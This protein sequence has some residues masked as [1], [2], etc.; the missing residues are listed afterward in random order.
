MKKLGVAF[1]LTGMVAAV[2][3]SDPS[4]IHPGLKNAI[5]AGNIE[6]AENIINK[7]GVDDLYCPATL[8]IS[9]AERLYAKRLEYRPLALYECD[10]WGQSFCDSAFAKKYVENSCNGKRP[11][12]VKVCSAWMNKST[13]REWLA[14]EKG[15]CGSKETLENC[16]RLI[17][18][19]KVGYLMEYFKSLEKKQL[20]QY[21]EKVPYDTTVSEPIPVKECLANIEENAAIQRMAISA[22]SSGTFYF[23]FGSC[24]FDGSKRSTQKCIAKFNTALKDVKT[25]CKKGTIKRDVRKTAYRK[26][27]ILPFSSQ[28]QTLRRNLLSRSLYNIDDSWLSDVRFLE[29]YIGLDSESEVVRRIK[30]DYASKGDIDINELVRGCRIYP[31]IDKSVAKEFGFELFSCEKLWNEY[32]CSEKTLGKIAQNEMVCDTNW[33]Y[34]ARVDLKNE[35]CENEKIVKSRFG[36]VSYKCKDGVWLTEA[37]D[38]FVDMRNGQLYKFVTIGSQVWMAENLNYD[39]G[40][41]FCYNNDLSNCEKYGRLY[42]WDAAREACPAGWHLP[43]RDEWNTLLSAVGGKQE[44]G[45]KLKSSAGWNDNHNGT[46]DYGFSALPAGY[47]SHLGDFGG[48]GN[49]AS[50]WSSTEYDS[51]DA[52]YLSINGSRAYVDYGGKSYGNWVR[53]LQD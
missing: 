12:D 6:L 37:E 14:F 16:K 22:K 43:S 5:D 4:K 21:E 29:K 33:Q 40:N 1:L 18:V 9:D 23:D 26:E 53:C 19:I 10:A 11:I 44:A 47:R 20:L 45:V 7:V 41:S 31:T 24:T 17:G 50:F 52:Y 49:Y 38:K 3:A 13:P 51:D 42:E 25:A 35:P 27:K 28:M 46:D 36:D 30:S 39:A 2:F 15:I 34:P 32:G 8:S 48:V